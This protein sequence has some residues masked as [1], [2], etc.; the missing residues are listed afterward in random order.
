MKKPWN[1]RSLHHLQALLMF[2][3]PIK[4]CKAEITLIT[5]PSDKAFKQIGQLFIDLYKDMS[6]NGMVIPL[7]PD[8]PE[9]WINAVKL[10]L[11][12]FACLAV[13]G[14]ADKITGFA[15][16]AIR[17]MPDY[18]GKIKTGIV[19]HIYVQPGHR[20]TGTGKLLLQKLETWFR[21]KEV[22]SVELQ[23][24]SGN[25]TAIKFWRE[26]GY[27]HELEQYRKTL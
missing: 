22:H 14:E 20:G 9:Q 11:N 10:S 2:F 26:N 19:T 18:L 3:N 5:D 1:R 7:S 23:V 12:R 15:H 6:D 13:A 8:G 21:S 4:M 16:G 24:V 25:F 27:M 17:F